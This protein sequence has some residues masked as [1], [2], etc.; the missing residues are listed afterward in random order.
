VPVT[1][2]I[3]DDLLVLT[4]VGQT[5]QADIRSALAVVISDPAFRQ[6]MNVLVDIRQ[7]TNV[8]SGE[9][10]Q[11]RI[12]LLIEF[13]P[14]VGRRCAVLATQGFLYGIANMFS[15]YARLRTEVDAMGFIDEVEAIAWLHREETRGE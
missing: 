4:L 6:G 14:L 3:R 15:T 9:E 13:R 2:T 8:L 12:K 5:T 7:S 1:H 10:V 11:E